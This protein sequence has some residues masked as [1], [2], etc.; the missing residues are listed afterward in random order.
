MLGGMI[1]GIALALLA[2]TAM[3]AKDEDP[4]EVLMR[5]REQVMAHA[6]RIPNHTCV[7]TIQ[8]DRYQAGGEQS[9]LSCDA[10]LARRQKSEFP[11]LLRFLSTDRL[12]LD[13]AYTGDREIYSWAGASRFEDGDID[14]LIHEGA[15]G[16]GAFASMLIAIFTE[17]GRFTFER[18]SQDGSRSLMEYS[19]RVPQELSRYRVKA[20]GSPKQWLITG[21]TGTLLL[22]ARTAELVRATVRTE[23]LR[24]E[25][26]LCETRTTLEF[27]VVKLGGVGYLLPKVARQRFI[28]RSG[29]EDE[30]SMTFSACREYQAES[31]LTFAAR[32]G[33]TDGGGPNLT[34]AASLPPGLPVIVELV[35][36]I[37][38]TRAAAGESIQGRLAKAIEGQQQRTLVVSGA[39]V[40][41]RLMRVENRHLPSEELAIAL[42]WETLDVDGV[43]TPLALRPNRRASGVRIGGLGGLRQRG[44]EFELPAPGEGRY[45]TFRFPGRDVQVPAGLRSEWL[46]GEQ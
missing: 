1:R 34:A 22:D 5:L 44:T 43:K 21:Y 3:A 4:V 29:S 33:K 9:R 30:N 41:G 45:A 38:G 42:C 11:T 24:P 6:G 46:T 10:L 20:Q 32:P 13:V 37:D 25:T 15:M 23:E 12:R 7:E 28:G 27:G 40:E 26:S 36:P 16:T 2:V 8:R 39:A 17:G 35:T 19:F 14:E 18:D 31:T